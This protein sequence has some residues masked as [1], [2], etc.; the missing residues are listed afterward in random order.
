MT[1]G[2]SLKDLKSAFKLLVCN[3]G[4]ALAALAVLAIGI[5]TNSTALALILNSFIQ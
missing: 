5:A 2:T 4:F 1:M 3:P